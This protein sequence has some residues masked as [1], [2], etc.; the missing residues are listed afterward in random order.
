MNKN[1]HMNLDARILIES[2]LSQGSS[3]KSI[4]TLLG[5]NCTTISKEIRN[6]LSFTNTSAYG[7]SFNDCV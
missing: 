7:R 4:G 5:K 2:E 6:H 3:F 1:K